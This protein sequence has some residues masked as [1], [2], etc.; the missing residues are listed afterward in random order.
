MKNYKVEVKKVKRGYGV[1]YGIAVLAKFKTEEQAQNSLNDQP[2]FYDYWA[3][4]ASVAYQNRIAEG[5]FKVI[6]C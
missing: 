3:N 1:V 2:K 4:S 6:N 5:D